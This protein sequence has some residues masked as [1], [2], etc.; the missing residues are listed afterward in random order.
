MLAGDGWTHKKK[1]EKKRK[2]KTEQNY[3]QNISKVVIGR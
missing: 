2:K 3:I 1:H